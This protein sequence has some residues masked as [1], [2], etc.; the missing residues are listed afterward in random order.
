MSFL[1]G[2]LLGSILSSGSRVVATRPPLTDID[3]VACYFGLICLAGFT[4]LV[5]FINLI[6]HYPSLRPRWWKWS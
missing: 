3:Y 5:I 1:F 4:L 6:K 2:L